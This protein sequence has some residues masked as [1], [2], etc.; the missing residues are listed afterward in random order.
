MGM[1]QYGILIYPKAWFSHEILISWIE[2]KWV[3]K[4]SFDVQNNNGPIV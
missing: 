1:N 2:K 4:Y 3:M